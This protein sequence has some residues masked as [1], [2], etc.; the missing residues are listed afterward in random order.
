[1]NFCEKSFQES[2]TRLTTA[3]ILTLLDG[4]DRFFVYYDTSRVGLGYVL[5]RR[6]KVVAYAS[7]KLKP[8][9]K[10]N[11]TYNYELA[12]IVFV[13]MIWRHYLYGEHVYVFTYHKSLQYV[14][15]QKDFNLHQKRWLELLKDYDM[16]VLYHPSKANIVADDLR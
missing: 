3:L 16:S 5:M 11:R 2:K 9:E 13:L 12:A 7:R 4:S 15:S 8:D 10:N 6:G 1:L 14:F